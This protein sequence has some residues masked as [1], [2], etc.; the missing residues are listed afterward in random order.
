M[1]TRGRQF[2]VA[3]FAKQR[4]GRLLRCLHSRIQQMRPL[5]ELTCTPHFQL[6]A[7]G[8]RD[9]PID[10]VIFRCALGQAMVTLR[11]KTECDG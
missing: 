8:R 3:H 4:S 1:Q 2:L 6:H 11:E 10:D 9:V 7:K 5:P